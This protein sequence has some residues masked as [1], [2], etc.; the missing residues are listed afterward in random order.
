M[1]SL[2]TT[3]LRSGLLISSIFTS[4]ISAETVLPLPSG[5]YAVTYTT[6]NLTDESR[7]DPL[8]PSFGKRQLMFSFFY[9]VEQSTCEQTCTIPYIPPKTAPYIDEWLVSLGIKDIP[10]GDLGRIQ[11]QVCCK[12]NGKENTD[13]S[14]VPLVFVLQGFTGT[15]FLHGALAQALASNG[16]AVVTLD[17]TFESAAVEFPDGTIAHSHNN[18][19]WDPTIPGRLDPLQVIRVED[20]SFVLSQLGSKEVAAKLVP[21]AS[22]GFNNESAAALGHSFGGSTSI[23]MLMNDTRFVGGLNLDGAQFGEITDTQQAG[24]LF[25]TTGVTPYPHNSTVDPTWAETLQH[26]KGW[27]AEIGLKNISHFGFTDM[28]YLYKSGGLGI[29]REYADTLIGP[30][31]GG[32]SSSIVRAY[33]TAFLNFVL[34]GKNTTLFDEPS[35]EFPEI[36]VL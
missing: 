11:M 10:S 5:P 22:C 1:Q 34:R 13:V 21:G 27:K 3:V 12:T 25:G 31:D 2:F 6:L 19:S 15:R 29:S 17:H 9:P 30:L 36:V 8:E 35:E 4:V 16:F 32:R 23:A 28:A 7:V 14:K 33:A 18:T 20:V 24:V 26:L